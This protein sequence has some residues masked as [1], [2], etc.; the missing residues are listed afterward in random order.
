[1]KRVLAV[2]SAAACALIVIDAAPAL[3]HRLDEYLEATTIQVS[4]QSVQLNLRLAPGVAVAQTVL[5]SIDVNHDGTISPDEESAYAAIVMN[6][7]SVS[8]DGQRVVLHP[9]SRRFAG[10]AALREGTGEIRLAFAGDITGQGEHRTL[11]FDNRH[12]AGIAA[13]LVN[14]VVPDDPA[15]QVVKQTRN[16]TQSDYELAFD[17]GDASGRPVSFGELGRWLLVALAAGA[18]L[19]SAATSSRRGIAGVVP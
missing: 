9:V 5:D 10:A 3:A 11:T 17:E 18:M 16:F 19:K 13:Y 15:I 12:R 1:M 7:L 8:V 2:A 4:R 6:D 14:A